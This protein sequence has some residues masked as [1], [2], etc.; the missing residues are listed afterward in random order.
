[1]SAHDHDHHHDHQVVPSDPALRTKALESLLVEK[2][3][4]DRAA[5]DALVDAYE[6]KIGPRNGARVV[7]RAWVDP[8]YKE[9]LLN[10]ASA[11]IA[12]LGYGGAQGE[13][14]VV[15]ENTSNVHNLVVCTL[16]SCYPWPILG[17]P[18][19]WYKSAPYRSRSV[20]D[21]RGVLREFGL[22]LPA[23]RRGS[24]L[25]Q[26]RGGPLPRLAGKT[27]R[28]G[29]HDRRGTCGPGHA[30][31]HDRRRQGPAPSWRPGMNGIHDMG[32]MQD[33][34]P[35]Q[36]E[37][38]EP[39]F[40]QPWEGRVFAMNRAIAAWRKWNIDAGR[41]GIE[42][43]PP[44][45]YLRM[46]YYEKWLTRNL[47]LL[48]KSGLVTREELE[49]GAPAPGSQKATPPL[50]AA[51]VSAIAGLRGNFMREVP[52]AKARFELGQQVRA[53][54]MNPVGHTRLP[55][56][57]RGKK[58]TVVRCHGVF[59]FPDTNAH[60]LGEQPQHLYSVRFAARE[61]WGEDAAPRD[62]VC[63]DMWDSYLDHA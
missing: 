53:R 27:G 25:R 21:P 58:G 8:A 28:H 19:V 14:M 24:R 41:Y 37:E 55:R 33:M 47:E 10:N 54:N 57:A 61:L 42:M 23:G 40:H 29:K 12:E 36:R 17:L 4:V 13:H 18:P 16:C 45:D 6:N 52:E 30:G 35:I 56:Y 39:V 48:V 44:A 63:I 1:M 26:H 50:T 5:L 11:A 22:E 34:G 3:L 49:T 38:N 15:L 59:V 46:S 7:A 60:F 20:I 9:R 51:A 32:G 2:G 31:L 62:S 43:L